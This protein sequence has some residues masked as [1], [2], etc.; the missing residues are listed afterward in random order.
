MIKEIHQDAD[1][2]MGKSLEVLAAHFARIRT[3]RAN[4]NLLDGIE[5]EYYG[6][7]TPLNQVASVSVEDAR[8]LVISPWEKKLIP[9]IEKAVLKSDLGI[10]PASTSEVIRVPLPALTEQNRKDLAKQARHEAENARIAIR[11]IRRDAIADIRELVKEKE[12]AEDEAH[13]GEENIQKLT[14]RW[15][16][17]VDKS[18]SAKEAD[19]MDVIVII[20]DN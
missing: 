15:I 19:L 8:T 4:P 9:D 11:N 20:A 2:R 7:P 17:E 1:E 3:G 18:L 16:G 6:N 14:D 10:T 12:V 5:V 13:R